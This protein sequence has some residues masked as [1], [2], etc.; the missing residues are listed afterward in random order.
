MTSHIHLFI[1]VEAD[2]ILGSYGPEQSGLLNWLYSTI[3]LLCCVGVSVACICIYSHNKREPRVAASTG[4]RDAIERVFT[5]VAL[6]ISPSFKDGSRASPDIYIFVLLR[7]CLETQLLLAFF[8]SV[9]PPAG[10]SFRIA[11]GG[12]ISF[13]LHYIFGRDALILFQGANSAGHILAS[14]V[15]ATTA[16]LM[17]VYSTCALLAPLL[18]VARVAPLEL[19]PF[20]ASALLVALSAAAFTG[21]HQKRQTGLVAKSTKSYM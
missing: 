14:I 20:I 6:V 4:I 18:Y 9:P 1:P 3:H 17:L 12:F 19:S 15:A 5:K 21:A 2:M 13:T 16:V 7:F 10:R 8:T 11:L